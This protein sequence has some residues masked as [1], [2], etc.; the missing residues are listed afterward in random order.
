VKLPGGARFEPRQRHRLL[1]CSLARWS[2][3][4][5]PTKK[6]RGGSPPLPPTR[7][8]RVRFLPGSRRRPAAARSKAQSRRWRIRRRRPSSSL[9]I[10]SSPHHA[11]P[12]TPHAAAKH[13]RLRILSAAEEQGANPAT[14]SWWPATPAAFSLLAGG[15][16]PRGC[17]KVARLLLERLAFARGI[18]PLPCC[19]WQDFADA[20]R[21]TAGDSLTICRAHP[22]T[23]RAVGFLHIQSLSSRQVSICKGVLA[24]GHNTPR[25][26]VAPPQFCGEENDRHH[27]CGE[28]CTEFHLSFAVGVHTSL[29][30]KHMPHLCGAA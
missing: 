17:A 11:L 12:S 18:S 25:P 26:G 4:G 13:L 15:N 19:I 1:P 16:C 3:H 21:V 20:E 22:L 6:G 14:T 29:S 27:N 23:Q 5:W 24:P 2:R 7:P 28:I 8:R 9:R 30:T 10:P